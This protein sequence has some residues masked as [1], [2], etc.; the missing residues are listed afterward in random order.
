MDFLE[1]QLAFGLTSVSPTLMTL[2]NHTL[3]LYQLY[4]LLAHFNEDFVYSRTVKEHCSLIFGKCWMISCQTWEWNT[5][6]S[7]DKNYRGRKKR[8]SR[9]RDERNLLASPFFWSSLGRVYG[10][11]KIYYTETKVMILQVVRFSAVCNTVIMEN[12]LQS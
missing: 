3:S 11:D 8:W 9:G 4:G 1:W 2:M 6:I 5:G 12:A 10:T 7:S